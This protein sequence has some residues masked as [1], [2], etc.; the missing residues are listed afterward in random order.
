M[1]FRLIALLSLTGLLSG[2]AAGD[3]PGSQRQAAEGA[4]SEV[5]ANAPAGRAVLSEQL[6]QFVSR[7]IDARLLRS[8]SNADVPAQPLLG[9]NAPATATIYNQA[10]GREDPFDFS[11]VE[12]VVSYADLARF[13]SEPSQG[14]PI[15][16]RPTRKDRVKALISLGLNSEALVAL[17]DLPAQEAEP[18][19][20][21]ARLMDRR[22]FVDG[23]YFANLAKCHE[24]AG[25]WLAAALLADGQ[26]GGASLLS[27]Q[28]SRFRK[29]PLRLR[30]D[31]ALISIPALAEFGERDLMSRVLAAFPE[32]DVQTMSR[33]RF[34][35]ALV[36]LSEGKPGA[37]MAVRGFLM[38][39]EFEVDALSALR[40]QNEPLSPAQRAILTEDV[41]RIVAQQTNMRQI[42]FATNFAMDEMDSTANYDMVI[43]LGSLPALQLPAAREEI[44]RRVATALRRDLEGEDALRKLIAIDVL[45]TR[46]DLLTGYPQI[47]ELYDLAWQQANGIG[48]KSLSIPLAEKSGRPSRLAEEQAAA[49]FLGQDDEALLSISNRETANQQVLFYAAMRAV[50]SGD[51]ARLNALEPS[52]QLNPQTL[53]TLIEEDAITQKW[54]VPDRFYDAARQLTDPD[55]LKKVNRVLAIRAAAKAPAGGATGRSV[56]D[57]PEALDRSRRALAALNAE[58]P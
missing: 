16:G 10:C 1:T 36:D 14:Q 37:A 46:E 39:P 32:H 47:D 30:A 5:A 58:T 24:S 52:L 19:I 34:C 17:R 57:V 3:P 23:A 6:D 48:R 43:R 45:I 4:T 51:A 38:K 50:Q 31:V 15:E 20:Q 22:H 13:E 54:V 35:K 56:A 18:L 25:L 9:T 7:A 27:D 11:A 41:T 21:L 44:Q 29:L 53:V 12:T 49:A 2:T 42:A 40:R 8:A 55:D 28:M 33:L 26:K